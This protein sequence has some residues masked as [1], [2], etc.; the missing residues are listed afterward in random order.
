M[1]DISL[2]FFILAICIAIC[3]TGRVPDVK[4]PIHRPS[5]EVDPLT[6]RS[7]L[8][9]D[10]E[11]GVADPWYDSSPSNTV[12]WG[13]EDLSSPTENYLPPT[14]LSGT[15]YLRATRDA[16]QNPGQLILRTLTFTAFPGDEISFNFWIRSKYTGG[17]VLEVY[18]LRARNFQKIYVFL[19]FV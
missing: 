17:N 16:L 10:F 7:L 15:K 14:P 8:N 13:V 6:A 11:S 2:H 18:I 4:V 5:S 3:W 1:K 9:N 19:I 12:Y